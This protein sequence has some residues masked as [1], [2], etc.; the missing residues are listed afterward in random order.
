MGVTAAAG[1]VVLV[2]GGTRGIG[3]ACVERFAAL[4]DR[5][6]ASS[7]SAPDKEESDTLWSLP[8]DQRSSEDVD[9]LFGRIEERWGPVQVLVANAG[10]NRDQLILRMGEDAWSE[11]VDTNLTGTYR[12]VKRAVGPMVRARQ[13]RIVLVSSVSGLAGQ[14]GQANYAASK[15]GLVG[16]ARSLAR[17]LAS[18]SILVNVVAPGPVETDML[19]ALSPQQIEELVARVPLGRAALP[20]EIAAAVAFLASPEASY[21]TGAVVPVDGGLAMGH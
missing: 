7:R 12:V 17:E 11:V 10:M 21:I 18:R 1:R 3:R 19:A 6:V 15:A 13:G 20:E 14:A 4:G 2:T 16:L 5:V 8:C 9:A